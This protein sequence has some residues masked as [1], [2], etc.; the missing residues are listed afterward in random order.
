MNKSTSTQ[1]KYTTIGLYQLLFWILIF[2]SSILFKDMKNELTINPNDILHE[3]FI[4]NSGKFLSFFI[5]WAFIFIYSHFS[6]KLFK[7]IRY[8]SIYEI[9]TIVVFFFCSVHSL[10]IGSH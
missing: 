5:A 7:T 9:K 4:T 10:K 8:N 6:S 1:P 2:L 3:N